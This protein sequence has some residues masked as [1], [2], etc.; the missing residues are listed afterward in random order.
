M[1]GPVESA[2]AARH[3]AVQAAARWLD[4]NPM[5][6]A[7][8]RFVSHVFTTAALSLLDAVGYD[9]PELT[10]S[11]DALVKAKDHAVRASLAGGR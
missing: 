2:A 5:L 11:L 10:K 3:P 1:I 4:V 8:Q 9:D 7:G 6:D